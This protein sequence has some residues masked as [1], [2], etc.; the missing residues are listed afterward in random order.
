MGQAVNGAAER[1]VGLGLPVE[2]HELRVEQDLREAERHTRPVAGVL[3]TRFKDENPVVDILDESCSDDS[4]C[5][6]AADDH[7]VVVLRVGGHGGY[8]SSWSEGQSATLA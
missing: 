8:L 2:P 1:L 7:E 6:A 4:S 3:G 5:G